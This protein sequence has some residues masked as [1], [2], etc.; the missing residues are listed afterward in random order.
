WYQQLLSLPPGVPS[1]QLSLLSPTF[2][3]ATDGI[4]LAIFSDLITGRAIAMDIYVTHDGGTTWKSTMPL[5]AAFGTIDLVDMQHGRVTD[6]KVLY[7]TNDGG[8]HWTEISPG[9]SLKQAA[10]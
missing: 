10:D 2:F 9:A 1:A 7:S 6:G 8:Q 3:P 5:P 4:L